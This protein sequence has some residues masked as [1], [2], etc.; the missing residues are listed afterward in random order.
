[1]KKL[2]LVSAVFLAALVSSCANQSNVQNKV[3]QEINAVPANKIVSIE[4]TIQ[5]EIATSNLSAEQKNAL[6]A[7]DE[8]RNKE[9]TAITEELEKA[10]V[11]LIETALSPKSTDREIN[12]IKKKIISLDK[13]RL[14]NGFKSLE[15]ARKIISPKKAD[16][17]GNE[18]Y[19]ATLQRHL[20]GI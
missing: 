20:K 10:K 12:V 6:I 4:K 8:K 1:M 5:E 18:I 9:Y 3:D 2:S 13:K 19:K 15:E 17:N 16:N 14:A 11:V 7:I